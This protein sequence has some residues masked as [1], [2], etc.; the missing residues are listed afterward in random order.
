MKLIGFAIA[1]AR[2]RRPVEPVGASC[3]SVGVGFLHR[4][5]RTLNERL[6]DNLQSASAVRAVDAVEPVEDEPVEA[7]APGSYRTW[8]SRPWTATARGQLRVR[9][10]RD[11]DLVVEEN[12][13]ESLSSLADAVDA[14]LDGAYRAVA[15]RQGPD[16]WSISARRIQVVPL[17][18]QGERARLVGAG[19]RI[20]LA[21]DGQPVEDAAAATELAQLALDLGEGYVVEATY[22][23]DGLWEVTAL[24][25]RA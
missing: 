7:E 15:V 12:V 1:R 25:T 8:S 6:L 22:L 17:S 2:L 19:G 5:R 16:W 20:D 10:A 11:G 23:D 13:E 21:V 3:Q 18:L 9:L 14:V 4:D 24:P